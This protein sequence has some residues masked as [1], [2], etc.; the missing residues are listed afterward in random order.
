MLL[1]QHHATVLPRHN[2]PEGPRN[3]SP[4][5]LSLHFESFIILL[6]LWFPCGRRTCSQ[7]LLE[8]HVE[9]MCSSITSKNS[10]AIDQWS[11]TVQLRAWCF[12]F[13][14][15]LH[16]YCTLTLL[17]SRMKGELGYQ[18][19][20]ANPIKFSAGGIIFSAFLGRKAWASKTFF[21]QES[22]VKTWETPHRNLA[23][24][25]VFLSSATYSL[26]PCRQSFGQHLR[27]VMLSNN[28]M[29]WLLCDNGGSGSA[30]N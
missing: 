26:G 14:V 7:W 30:V 9:N 8:M 18:Q 10:C 17:F 6:Y 29:T 22:P 11:C 2:W 21:L 12:S 15:I 4:R 24:L 5:H 20:S 23:K 19:L 27:H 16:S 3:P 28:M 13:D 1:L 25:A